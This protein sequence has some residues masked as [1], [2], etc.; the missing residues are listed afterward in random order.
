[1]GVH[2]IVSRASPPPKISGQRNSVSKSILGVG[3]RLPWPERARSPSGVGGDIAISVIRRKSVGVSAFRRVLAG[4]SLAI[5]A[6]RCAASRPSA[7]K[8]APSAE[9]ED[10]FKSLERDSLARNR[11]GGGHLDGHQER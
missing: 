10:G 1:V 9:G 3:G 6:T 5:D 7:A 4:C 8:A 2:D 11:H